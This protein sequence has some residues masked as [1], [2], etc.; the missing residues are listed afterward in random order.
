MIEEIFEHSSEFLKELYKKQEKD[1]ISKKIIKAEL[2]TSEKLLEFKPKSLESFA[3]E[4]KEQQININDEITKD[5]KDSFIKNKILN[6]LT[7][8]TDKIYRENSIKSRKEQLNSL[9]T[10]VNEQLIDLQKLARYGT[11]SIDDIIRMA[12]Y[13]LSSMKEL[14]PDYQLKNIYNKSLTGIAE[15]YFEGLLSRNSNEAQ[16]FLQSDFA[17]K[18]IKEG[19]LSEIQVKQQEN[20][21]KVKNEVIK[22]TELKRIKDRIKLGYNVEAQ[23]IYE[24]SPYIGVKETEILTEEN[25]F[26]QKIRKMNVNELEKL[27]KTGRVAQIDAWIST[28]NSQLKNNPLKTADRLGVIDL[29][30]VDFNNENSIRKR[31][32]DIEV[33]QNHYG[34]D[35]NGLLEEEKKE[36]E[37]YLNNS[38]STDVL[39]LGKQLYQ[40]GT[41]I[42]SSISQSY[43]DTVKYSQTP[44]T[45]AE[46][47]ALKILEG[48]KIKKTLESKLKFNMDNIVGNT[49][50][51]NPEMINPLRDRV[52]SYLIDDLKTTRGFFGNKS[53]DL[54]EPTESDVRKAIKSVTGSEIGELNGSFYLTPSGYSQGDVKKYIKKLPVLKDVNGNIGYLKGKM[55]Y[56][57]DIL[58]YG[59]LQ[60]IDENQY[61]VYMKGKDYLREKNGDYFILSFS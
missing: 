44:Y 13:S 3:Q 34:I 23:E 4:F 5:I 37:E 22:N 17:K 9:S 56:P 46:T 19:Y 39:N 21:N 38:T 43:L 28:L 16:L 8:N 58:K 30:K 50:A 59:N 32:E 18:H 20:I 31:E 12:D 35:V 29:E 25:Q 1:I 10:S 42:L 40:Y 11:K 53:F 57:A 45:G 47:N 26:M 27:R 60:M 55:V 7:E 14:I 51:F 33:I 6:Y 48:E 15:S 52:E 2:L 36:I 61:L 41:N 54:P 24:L 49:F